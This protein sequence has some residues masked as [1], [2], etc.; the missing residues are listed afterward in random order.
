MINIRQFKSSDTN[1]IAQLFHDTIRSVNQKDYS[2]E[3]LK[4]WAPDDI[5]FHDWEEKCLSKLTLVADSDGLIAGFVQFENDGHIDCFYCHKDFQGKGVG[6]LLFEAVEKKA[7][8]QKLTKLFVEASI[9]A[10][11]FFEKMGF[12]IV[13]RQKVLTKG[14][15]LT[16]YQMEK[17]VNE[18]VSNKKSHK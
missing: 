7:R 9:T 12:S 16:N 13:K 1:Q 5:H 18:V 11:P 4:A 15:K 2:D 8:K 17:F 10:K 6:R 14:I 3:Q